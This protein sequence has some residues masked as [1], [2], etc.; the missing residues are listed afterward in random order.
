[1]IRINSL[2]G[3]QAY[4]D[5]NVFIYTLN[6]FQ[7]FLTVLTRLFSSVDSG[8]I[9]AVTSELALAELLVKPIRD[10]DIAAQQTCQ[11]L[12]LDNPRL[13]V[14][15][16]TR[17]TLIESAHLRAT[18]TLKLPDALHLATARLGG[19]DLFLTNDERF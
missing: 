7:P 9:Q 14:K 8:Q 13:T 11:S 2:T 1:M 17:Q 12:L 4:L 15:P 6:A 16:I 3:R 19:C 18:T 5:A 10:G